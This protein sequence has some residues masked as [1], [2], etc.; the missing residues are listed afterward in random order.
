MTVSFRG[1]PTG[2]DPLA[3]PMRGSGTDF[4]PAPR[5][6]GVMLLALIALGAS[7][8][9][10]APEIRATAVFSLGKDASGQ[11]AAAMADALL[12]ARVDAAR[13]L[14]LIEPG[15]VL[16]GDPRTREEE[17]LERARAALADGRRAYDA[18]ALDD[19]I[20]RLGQAVSLYQQT[21]PLLGDLGELR[22][23]LTYL[24]ASLV[25]RGSA[26]EAESTF[27]ELLTVDPSHTLVGFP[28][29]VERVFERAAA[30][31]DATASGGVEIYSTPPYAGVYLDG[32]F[33][34]VTPLVLEDVVAG[35]HYLRLEKLGYTIHG[36]P[37]QIA[38]KQRIT[39]QTRLASLTRG[40]ELRDLAA[41]SV[42]EVTSA[43]MGG[44]TRELARQL[45]ADSVIFVTVT[46]SGRDAAFVGAVFDARAGERVA[47]ER[48]VLSADAATFT[49]RLG[50][51]LDRLVSSAESGVPSPGAT[52]GA[53][54]PEGGAF[55]LGAAP[56]QGTGEVSGTPR[57]GTPAP[58]GVLVEPRRERPTP[59]ELYLGWTLVGV[60]GVAVVTGVVFG[61]LTLDKHA[62][63]RD[64]TQ[65]SPELGDIRDEGKTFATTADILF[66]SG[67]ALLVGGIT[68]VLVSEMTRS[69]PAQTLEGSVIP[70][71]G[72]AMVGLGG[73]F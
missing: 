46:Q 65:L 26:D 2:F 68:T 23:A 48:V 58:S 21:G 31:I 52:A 29:T 41:R 67:G 51:Y 7:A 62:D 59:P 63:F 14:R 47:T 69:S 53:P 18:L 72:G 13:N 27:V 34:G 33:E 70:I 1:V 11:K 54:A 64:T 5:T 30:R 19:A 8:A 4:A 66:A 35:T 43:G 39:S 25:L 20:A 38:P 32:R 73:Q 40:A 10:A 15:R 28:P 60:G 37:L 3:R 71:E 55:G 56:S 17:T 6:F 50:R 61:I 12:R 42:D 9:H 22:T 36:A 57:V 44:H 49:D 45:V 24:A 16:S